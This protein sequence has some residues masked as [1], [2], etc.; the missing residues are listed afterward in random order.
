MRILNEDLAA[1]CLT[2]STTASGYDVDDLSNFEQDDIWKAT[3]QTATIT[4]TNSDV[5]TS[6]FAIFNCNDAGTIGYTLKNGA[7]TVASG[8]M[9]VDAL[10]NHWLDSI[11]YYSAV[12]SIVFSIDAGFGGIAEA[13]ILRQSSIDS[14]NILPEPQITGIWFKDYSKSEKNPNGGIV[15][16]IEK[17]KVWSVSG[18]VRDS[19]GG[20]N[21]LPQAM[22]NVKEYGH[23]PLAVKVYDESK[24]L[25][26]FGM[27]TFNKTSP[28]KDQSNDGAVYYYYIPFVI[29]GVS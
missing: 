16:V 6:D 15:Q 9:E 21:A 3:G 12:T 23:A 22:V 1:G 24:Q 13:G 28:A 29:E 25:F 11:G 18:I 17:A 27:L 26:I 19:L 10:G 8:A 7:A 4:V 5:G 20:V 14:L 2:A